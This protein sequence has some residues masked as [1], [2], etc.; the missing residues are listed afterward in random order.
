MRKLCMNFTNIHK[1]TNH[2]LP[3]SDLQKHNLFHTNDL[4]KMV[5]S[6][7][8]NKYPKIVHLV[9]YSKNPEYDEMLEITREYYRLFSNV[10][11]LY[12]CFCPD[13]ETEYELNEKENILYI[14]GTET[15]IPGILD[16][17]VKAFQYVFEHFPD[18]D[19]V[20]RTNI[21]TIVNLFYLSSILQQTELKYGS[22]HNLI[23]PLGY[24]DPYCGINDDRY[25]GLEYPS[26][27]AIILHKM[28]VQKILS[29]IQQNDYNV[30]DDVAI[31]HCIRKIFPDMPLIHFSK[32]YK[33]VHPNNMD[34]MDYSQ[35]M[36]Y[37]N[38]NGDRYSD[39]QN[40]KTIITKLTRVDLCQKMISSY[41]IG[42]LIL[43]QLT[44]EEKQEIVED[45]PG[46]IATQFILSETENMSV[47]D[48]IQSISKIV[49][50][51]IETHVNQLPAD[52]S[53][54]TVIHLRL[55]DV[56]QGNTYHEKS[57]RPIELSKLANMLEGNQQ[58]KYVIGNIFFA[59]PSS[60]N[61]SECIT[62]SNTYLRSVLQELGAE[63]YDSKN[64]DL[65]L[66][67]AVKCD[68]FIQGRG[69]YSQ[70]ISEIRNCPPSKI[71][72]YITV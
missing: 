22:S 35:I 53:Q 34:T 43:V 72:S 13:L 1:T 46:S 6:G 11:T 25:V 44:P 71:S 31:G 58:K 66:C 4:P 38:K 24:I 40:M 20:L 7:S 37:R 48:K 47:A 10:Y 30:I 19:Y 21:S 9:L 41:R 17:T 32:Y 36:F 61:Y 16:K 67:C 52:I 49:D 3:K 55:G 62:A 56:I 54:S 18:M 65:D 5:H 69:Y 2:T 57:K 68:T 14:Q 50:T 39:I 64:A 42:D 27:T 63:H 12:Y 23:I 60:T 8:P 59:K 45:F 26:G 33:C 70:L 51:Y 15:I 29:N 28:I